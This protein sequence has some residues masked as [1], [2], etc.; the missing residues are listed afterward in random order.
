LTTPTLIDVQGDTNLRL[1]D[2]TDPNVFQMFYWNGSAVQQKF[3]PL[4]PNGTKV[5][6][7]FAWDSSTATLTGYLN[8]VS[9]GSLSAGPFATPDPSTLSFGYFGRA[10]FEG[11]GIDGTLDA[12]S[13]Q[14]GTAAFNPA[15]DFLILPVTQSFAAWIGGFPGVGEL[16]GFDDDADGDGL[17]NGVEG[18]MGTD[19]SVANGS[20]VTQVS[21]TGTVTTFSH[22]MASQALSDVTASYEW[23]PD[24]GSWYAGD[25][26]D[27]PVGGPTVSIPLVAPLGGTAS[28]TATSSVPLSQLFIRIVA[29]N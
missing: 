17:A 1:R 28:V 6:L 3:T 4:A 24:L 21:T 2:L 29:E 7:A 9:F 26:V 14:T 25:G 23:S 18:F 12:V 8:G 5:H 16:D 22:P 15:T 19:P 13:F 20:F 27:G 11:R 10:G